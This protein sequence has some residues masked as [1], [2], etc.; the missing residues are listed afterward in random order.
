MDLVFVGFLRV[1]P[2]LGSEEQLC[3]FVCVCVSGV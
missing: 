3:V 2:H 1:F